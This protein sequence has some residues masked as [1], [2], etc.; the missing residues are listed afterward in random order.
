MN[1]RFDAAP[2]GGASTRMQRRHGTTLTAIHGQ[3]TVETRR[4][5]KNG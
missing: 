2:A 1:R 3:E 5:D 4:M